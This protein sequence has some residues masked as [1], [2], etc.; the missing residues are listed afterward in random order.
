M[1]RIESGT[2]PRDVTEEAEADTPDAGHRHDRQLVRE[3]L[4]LTPRQRLE[5]LAVVEQFFS[6]ARRLE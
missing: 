1:L 2:E 5:E 3:L 6:R 4:A